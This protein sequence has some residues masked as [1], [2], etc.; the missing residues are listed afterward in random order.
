MWFWTC[1]YNGKQWECVIWPPKY[2]MVLP[3][4]CDMFFCDVMFKSKETRLL[5]EQA[6]PR[7][8]K[9]RKIVTWG[10]K[11]E[12]QKKGNRN[13]VVPRSHQQLGFYV[14]TILWWFSGGIFFRP[15]LVRLSKS[16]SYILSLQ[17]MWF[18]SDQK[19]NEEKWDIEK[20]HRENELKRK[21]IVGGCVPLQITAIPLRTLSSS[22]QGWK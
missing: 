18:I 9:Q 8:G 1:F 6:I 17:Q 13:G 10:R 14:L 22:S 3:I 19:A 21:N 7:E 2:K 20:T 16:I 12:G 15:L 5:A 11:E 4:L